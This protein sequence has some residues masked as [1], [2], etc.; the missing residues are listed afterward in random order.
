MPTTH[1]PVL[2]PMLEDLQFLP[3]RW[4][5]V[6]SPLALRH[7]LTAVLCQCGDLFWSKWS[8]WQMNET[9]KQLNINHWPTSAAV[10]CMD[11]CFALVRTWTLYCNRACQ[12]CSSTWTKVQRQCKL[13]IKCLETP[14]HMYVL[15]MFCWFYSCKW[16]TKQTKNKKFIFKYIC[17][18]YL[19]LFFTSQCLHFILNNSC[20]FCIMVNRGISFTKKG[21]ELCSLNNVIV[22]IFRNF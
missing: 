22:I 17:F 2:E 14:T 15:R 9:T 18:L 10:T 8:P 16:I 7:S 21:Y 6:L 20:A 19:F 4:N 1:F 12:S 13:A 5:C 3:E 11:M